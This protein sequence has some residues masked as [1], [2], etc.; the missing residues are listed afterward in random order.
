MFGEKPARVDVLA[1]WRRKN[2]PNDLQ[3][4]R[5]SWKKTAAPTGGASPFP[6]PH[7]NGDTAP[8]WHGDLARERWGGE[9]LEGREQPKIFTG[10][11]YILLPTG[12]S[13]HCWKGKEKN[14]QAQ[15]NT[16]NSALRGGVPPPP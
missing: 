14:P 9:E 10:A 7:R 13:M 15:N 11:F 5:S 8:S 3:S 4:T 2:K 12:L 16:T 1:W 6:L